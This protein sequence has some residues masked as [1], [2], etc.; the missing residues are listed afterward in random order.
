MQNVIF[1]CLV[2]KPQ[3]PNSAINSLL[4]RVSEMTWPSKTWYETP[5]YF[6]M[7]QIKTSIFFSNYWV[8]WKRNGLIHKSS[9]KRQNFLEK[10]EKGKNQSKYTEKCLQLCKSWNGSVT[11]VDELREILKANCGKA[12]KIYLT[13]GIPIKLM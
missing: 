7:L 11:S 9:V 12:E 8:T 6:K 10:I 2:R 1:L 4:Q 5:K 3:L 13:I